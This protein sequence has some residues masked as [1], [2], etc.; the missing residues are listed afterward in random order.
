MRDAPLLRLAGRQHWLVRFDQLIGLGYNPRQI[1]HRVDAGLLF[2]VYRKVYGVPGARE[3]TLQFRVMA[4]CLAAD[5]LASHSCAAM[6]FG[7]RR[8]T[9]DEV[10]ITVEGRRAPRL[11]G[12]RG[13]RCDS[14][15]SSDR[16]TIGRI[17]VTAPARILLDVAG[18]LD[19]AV[20][21]SALD[22]ALTRRLTTLPALR[23]V[24]D[25]VDGG[26]PGAPLLRDLLEARRRGR[27]P[28]ESR[29][30][31]DLG[32]LLR[33]FGLPEPV[34][35]HEVVLPGGGKAR[36]DTAYPN[37]LLGIEADGAEY[38]AGRLDHERDAARDALCRALGWTIRRFTTEE[39]RE[40]PADVAAVVATLLRALPRRSA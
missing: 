16:V 3:W 37:Q 9:S 25:A 20:L 36:L 15:D 38:H 1:Q 32:A 10:D 33:R 24:L 30:E 26:R 17:P 7:L 31:D 11:P 28:T 22:D 27:R 5:A 12:V 4:A 29:L 6:L 21:E 19:P 14:L 8:I 35:Q 18:E 40:H 39:I 23:R 13:H 34:R 2:R